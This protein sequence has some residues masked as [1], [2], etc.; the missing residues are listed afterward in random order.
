LIRLRFSFYAEHRDAFRRSNQRADVTS[1][2][3]QIVLPAH[4]TISEF[5]CSSA[6][7]DIVQ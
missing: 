3:D 6:M 1:I 4:N 7:I 5:L 2:L